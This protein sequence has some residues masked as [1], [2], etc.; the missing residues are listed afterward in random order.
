MATKKPVKK[1][2]QQKV[3]EAIP[4][5]KPGPIEGEIK[6][7]YSKVETISDKARTA[8]PPD[9]LPTP[10]SE[11]VH[12]PSREA[13]LSIVGGVTT[14]Q[15]KEALIVQTEQRTIIQQFIKDNLVVDIDY[16]KIH[17]VKGCPQE[18]KAR[19]S[20]TKSYHFSKSILFKPGQ[21]KIFSLFG[22][23]DELVKDLDAYEMLG[24]MPG[25]V[26]YK[27]IMYR[28]DNRVGEGRGAAT[29]GGTQNDPNS[30]IKKAEKRA[31]MDACLSL[32][33][34]AYFTQDLDD[35]DYKSQRDM[36]NEK[37]RNE[38]ERI[39]KDEFGLLPRDP[40]LPVDA[41]ERPLLFNMI[42]KTG[43]DKYYVIDALKLNG[44][45]KPE[46]MTSGQARMMMGLIKEGAF[47][48]PEETAAAEPDP[49]PEPDDDIDQTPTVPEAELV[50][51]DDLRHN[52]QSMYSTLG[53]NARGDMWF[54]KHV[55]GK[56]FGTW[57]K[58]SAAEWRKAFDF[59]Q[60]ILDNKVVVPDDYIAGLVWS[61]PAG[62]DPSEPEANQLNSDIE[63][64]AAVFPGAQEIKDE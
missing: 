35:P 46:A 16:G 64:V 30:T 8:G 49:D 13:A 23:T 33:F 58:Y 26:A 17:V 6:P 62:R 45:E 34:S 28:G 60:E 61:D 11:L 57:D 50:V 63:Q 55:T 52:V 38:A 9:Q 22:I 21:E 15:L 29:L 5:L 14:E 25:L 43:V 40:N 37:A 3:D 31:R 20:C 36:M 18:E 41:K 42:L 53:L 59:I 1:T 47:K 24:N 32:G 51:D 44:V 19:G 39:D 56:P 4:D 7:D 12:A 27:C 2:L 10:S 48:K 54:K